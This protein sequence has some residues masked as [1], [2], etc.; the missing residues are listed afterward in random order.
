MVQ[1]N[2]NKIINEIE[3]R[4]SIKNFKNQSINYIIN[5]IPI[6]NQNKLIQLKYSIKR[7]I[8][9]ENPIIQLKNIYHSFIGIGRFQQPKM[10]IS[11][12]FSFP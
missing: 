3:I 1:K 6:I 9:L 2:R 12:D 8:Q 11:Y 5:N 10:K 4:N 7:F